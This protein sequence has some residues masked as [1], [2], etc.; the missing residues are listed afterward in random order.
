MISVHTIKNKIKCLLI[1]LQIQ[2][3]IG[4]KTLVS[5]EFQ[6]LMN[7]K[8]TSLCKYLKNPRRDPILG[9]LLTAAHKYSNILSKCPLVKVYSRNFLSSF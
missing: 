4:R 7:G 6:I 3:I 1:T 8:R 9:V 2:Y 5:S